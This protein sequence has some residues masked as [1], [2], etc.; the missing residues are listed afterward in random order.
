MQSRRNNPRQK[1]GGVLYYGNGYF[2]QC[3][4][5]PSD[6]VNKL[7]SRIMQDDRHDSFEI[8]KVSPV[9]ERLFN[10]WSMKFIPLEND[11][12]KLLR[13]FG[14]DQFSP[15]ILDEALID[16]MVDLFAHAASPESRPDQ[17]YQD[18]AKHRKPSLWTRIKQKLFGRKT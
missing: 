17:N 11:I 15:Q 1:I 9:S 14:H 7:S 4:E 12:K 8:V 13:E 3:L 10:N 18:K 5:G 2:F 6:A 16:R